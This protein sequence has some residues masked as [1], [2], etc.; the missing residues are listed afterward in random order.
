MDV[1]IK[2]YGYRSITGLEY[3]IDA[4]SASM[5]ILE[6][7]PGIGRKRAIRIAA[8]RPFKNIDEFNKTMDNGFNPKDVLNWISIE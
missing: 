7:I 4:N 6:N 3:P 8:N 1:K 5:A 2:G